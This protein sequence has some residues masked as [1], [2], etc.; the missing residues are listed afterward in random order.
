MTA[1]A[2]KLNFA[3]ARKTSLSLRIHWKP[4]TSAAM[5]GPPMRRAH[6]RSGLCGWIGRSS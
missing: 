4:N 2:T 5:S 1:V 3:T 6:M